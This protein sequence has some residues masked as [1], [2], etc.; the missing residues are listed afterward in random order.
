MPDEGIPGGDGKGLLAM[1][2]D[3]LREVA[4]DEPGTASWENDGS[5]DRE[6]V[7]LVG[8]QQTLVLAARD[9]PGNLKQPV[10]TQIVGGQRTVAF[11]CG[12]AGKRQAHMFTTERRQ[13]EES[14][15]EPP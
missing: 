4:I 7:V 15:G 13:H 6:V 14:A 1:W 5:V 3:L 2:T 8:D 10:S 9:A 11:G 12:V